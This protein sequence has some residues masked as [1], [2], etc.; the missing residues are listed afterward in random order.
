MALLALLGGFSGAGTASHAVIGAATC[1]ALL[2][3]ELPHRVAGLRS[4]SV[5]PKSYALGVAR[6]CWRCAPELLG[7]TLCMVAACLL[8]V[9]GPVDDVLQP[10][11]DPVLWDQIIH[12]EWPI[13]CG[14]DTL[15]CLQ[16]WLR[17]IVLMFVAVRSKV[18]ESVPL[19]GMAAV[20]FLSATLARC[21]LAVRTDAYRLEGPLALGGDLPIACEVAMLPR[22][23]W[24][25]VK[26]V[27]ETPVAASAWVGITAWFASFHYLNLAQQIEGNPDADKFWTLANALEFAAGI[28]FMC[29]TIVSHCGSTANKA[30][31]MAGFMHLVM[32]AQA[33]MGAYFYLHFDSAP[34]NVGSG[35][36]Y[37]LLVWSNLLQL[38]AYLISSA[39]FISSQFTSDDS[40]QD[41]QPAAVV[42][43]RQMH[44]GLPSSEVVDAT[45]EEVSAATEVVRQTLMM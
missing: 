21:T 16:T 10:Q 7:V 38:G 40:G 31:V 27:R 28:A 5:S 1:F 25:S 29:N 30:G 8:R 9:R 37:C 32:L 44:G 12:T 24:L 13:L 2:G 18:N 41:D 17:L 39:F 22:L 14:P 43:E 33:A 34:S 23:A 11:E 6:I 19:G 20:L 3:F 45:A 36:P 15:L 26:A 4:G 42:G 35:R